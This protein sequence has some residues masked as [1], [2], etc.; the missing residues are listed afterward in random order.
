[1]LVRS[2]SNSRRLRELYPEMADAE[3][4]RGALGSWDFVLSVSRSAY[5]VSG[6][7]ATG[8]SAARLR[9]FARRLRQDDSLRER[10]ASE[11]LEVPLHDLDTRASGAL[12]RS[13]TMSSGAAAEALIGEE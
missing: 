8:T 13:Q 10:L 9:R 4:V 3:T 12:S 2:L 1:M 11:M 6:R 7:W 5:G